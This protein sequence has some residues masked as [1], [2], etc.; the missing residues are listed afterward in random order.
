VFFVLNEGVIPFTIQ[1]AKL[2][3]V[4]LDWLMLTYAKEGRVSSVKKSIEAPVGYN[5]MSSINARSTF[6]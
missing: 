1:T 2:C 5:K 3:E 6:E 4:V